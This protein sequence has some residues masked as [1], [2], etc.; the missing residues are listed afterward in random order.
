MAVETGLRTRRIRLHLGIA[1]IFVVIV[2]ALTAGTIW[3]NHRL[4]SSAALQTADQLFVE[5]ATKVDERINGMLGAVRA[6]VDAASAM[7]GFSG[8]PRYDGLSH[9][10]LETMIRMFEAQPHVFAVF[11]GF[12]S[13]ES[14]HGLRPR[15]PPHCC[16]RRT[17][18]GR[19]S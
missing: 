14:N 19:S 10:A 4:A 18:N 2:A 6:T 17:R 12:G 8:Q 13:G 5:I 1:S 9:A 15:Q 11:T 16:R 3:N 7:P